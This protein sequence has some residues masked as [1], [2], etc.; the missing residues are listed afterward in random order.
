M[1]I[2]TGFNANDNS[3]NII[4]TSNLLEN[5]YPNFKGMILENE[6]MPRGLKVEK[7]DS[8][9][10][11]ITFPIPEAGKIK[12][13]QSD[14]VD[15]MIVAIDK[16]TLDC[17]CEAINSFVNACLR[18]KL[19][20][21]EFLPIGGKD[22]GITDLQKDVKRAISMKSNFCLIDTYKEFLDNEK[23]R[24][25]KYNQ[26]F[27]KYGTDEYSDVAIDIMEGKLK[28]VQKKYESKLKLTNWC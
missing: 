27:I 6:G 2:N 1:N 25:Y 19:R 8:D 16:T 11:V 10:A 13:I 18:Y 23:S 3:L 15:K 17:I 21:T 12:T 14:S 26:Y 5:Y 7:Q 9:T 4:V 28:S 22:Y 24:K 20:T